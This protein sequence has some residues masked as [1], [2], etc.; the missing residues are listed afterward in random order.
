MQTIND[1]DNNVMAVMDNVFEITVAMMSNNKPE[2]RL[3]GAEMALRINVQRALPLVLPLLQ[4]SVD[5]VRAEIC[6]MLQAL[7]DVRATEAVTNLMLS[8]PDGTIRYIAA[9]TLGFI[10]GQ[11]ALPILQWVT[12]HDDGTDW[13]GRPIAWKAA[14][15]AEAIQRRQGT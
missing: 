12:N 5:Y 8:D 6:T 15:A 7:G 11:E 13:E 3:Y 1:S 10:G 14:E 4:D 2:L 9:A